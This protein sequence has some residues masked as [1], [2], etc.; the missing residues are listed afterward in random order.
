MEV[1]GSSNKTVNLIFM[2]GHKMVCS[3]CCK[4]EDSTTFI[5]SVTSLRGS[6]EEQREVDVH[7]ICSLDE[8]HNVIVRMKYALSSEESILLN[9]FLSDFRT[10]M[11]SVL[12]ASMDVIGAHCNR[13]AVRKDIYFVLPGVCMTHAKY[14][15]F[16]SLMNAAARIRTG[17]DQQVYFSAF[18]TLDH[19]TGSIESDEDGLFPDGP[20]VFLVNFVE[21]Q[22]LMS[23]A[24]SPHSFSLFIG[25]CHT[26][27][28]SSDSPMRKEL[29]EED[30]TPKEKDGDFFV[31]P[32]QP[33]TGDREF[34][35]RVCRCALFSEPV[36]LYIT[37]NLD[38]E[39]PM[40]VKGEK[41]VYRLF[42]TNKYANGEFVAAAED[43]TEMIAPILRA[44]DR[45]SIKG[46]AEQDDSE[47]V[48]HLLTA[49][50]LNLGQRVLVYDVLLERTTDMFVGSVRKAD[51][52]ISI[53]SH[54]YPEISVLMTDESPLESMVTYNV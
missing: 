41:L 11:A 43:H 14:G 3:I 6:D 15:E 38:P 33:V 53:K 30:K 52:Q 1:L 12:P 44:V 29:E 18:G 46:K 5:G 21:Y 17:L 35:S 51:K 7:E 26:L 49:K 28:D 45:R 54:N 42:E 9:E 40:T 31:T 47:S 32:E 34:L 48:D 19:V 8:P 50:P 4:P 10:Y 27:S 20:F 37:G 16:L 25:N 24:I 22:N 23:S 39:G 2:D 36:A 13:I